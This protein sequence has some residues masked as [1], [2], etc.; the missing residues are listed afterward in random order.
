MVLTAA[1]C[2]SVYT[3]G[4]CVPSAGGQV[5]GGAPVNG[6]PVYQSFTVTNGQVVAQY[7][8]Q[9]IIVASGQQTATIQVLA[10]TPLGD[11][12]SYYALGTVSVRLLA[13]ATAAVS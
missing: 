12:I 4:Y 2:G 13:P 11:I 8:S 10:A 1:N 5:L 9:G 3:S 7:S 6:N